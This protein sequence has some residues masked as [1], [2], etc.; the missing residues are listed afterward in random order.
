[1]PFLPSLSRTDCARVSRKEHAR[2]D[3]SASGDDDDGGGARWTTTTTTKN[4]YRDD[5]D[6]PTTSDGERERKHV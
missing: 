1:M 5:G 2:D 3:D 6:A 4:Q